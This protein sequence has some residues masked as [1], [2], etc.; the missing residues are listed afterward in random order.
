ML[1]PAAPPTYF[2]LS[3]LGHRV[4]DLLLGLGR[5]PLAQAPLLRYALVGSLAAAIFQTATDGVAEA[6]SAEA[7]VGVAT[8]GLFGSGTA[9][10][11]AD[12]AE[13]DIASLYAY[14]PAVAR[15]SRELAL[16][17]SALAAATLLRS[18]DGG[19]VDVAAVAT[20]LLAAARARDAHTADGWVSA[21]ATLF[22]DDQ[23]AEADLRY[24]IRRYGLH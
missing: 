9:T 8:A 11:R 20:D 16:E 17:R 14:R 23:R 24:L 6:P 4:L 19:P 12:L 5:G 2:R 10:S 21:A 3:L 7:D 1:S 13:V 18:R 15:F 22:A